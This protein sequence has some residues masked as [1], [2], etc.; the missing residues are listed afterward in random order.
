MA[1]QSALH[2]GERIA[3]G[4]GG[5][6]DGRRGRKQEGVLH[7]SLGHAPEA[8]PRTDDTCERQALGAIITSIRA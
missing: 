6:E 5:A 2:I 1:R 8:I 4:G 3:V 7:R